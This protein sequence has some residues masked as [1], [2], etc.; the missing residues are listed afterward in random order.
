VIY[1]I[2]L[3]IEFEVVKFKFKIDWKRWM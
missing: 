1:V 3:E 2:K